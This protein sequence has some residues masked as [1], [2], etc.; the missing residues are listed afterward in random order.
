MHD[1]TQFYDINAKPEDAVIGWTAAVK[2]ACDRQPTSHP[3]NLTAETICRLMGLLPLYPFAVPEGYVATGPMTVE[4][5][6][7]AAYKRYETITI[8]EHEQ[9][10]AADRAQADAINAAERAAQA[11]NDAVAHHGSFTRLADALSR[12]PGIEAGM[13]YADIA[14]LMDAYIEAHPDEAGTL[15]AKAVR[16]M[17]IFRDEL[18]PTG[19]VNERFW[20]ALEAVQTLGGGQ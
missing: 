18:E 15:T 19:V 7:G 20:R 6:D 17:S 3:E 11:F 9:R 2:R 5:E 12:F 4:I 13:T 1:A 16:A 14:D 10:N 8:E